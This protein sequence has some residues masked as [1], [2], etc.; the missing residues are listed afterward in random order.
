MP[1]DLHVHSTVSDGTQTPT[2]IVRDALAIGLSAIALADHDSIGGVREGSDAAV[3][4]ALKVIPAVEI[5]TDVGEREAHILGYF[6]DIDSQPLNEQLQAIRRARLRRYL[7]RE[8]RGRY[9]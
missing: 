9:S 4:T 1:I 6:V 5:N 7:S 8:I 3:G 2:E